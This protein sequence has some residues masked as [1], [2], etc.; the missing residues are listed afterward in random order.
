MDL[1]KLVKLRVCSTEK[2]VENS[3][4]TKCVRCGRRVWMIK[5]SVGGLPFCIDCAIETLQKE[6]GHA[7]E[8]DENGKI[9]E[10]WEDPGLAQLV[11]YLRWLRD[12]DKV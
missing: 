5:D 11:K 8:I 7:V 2:R 10:R 3:F 12:K 6:G 4:P 9:V 1:L